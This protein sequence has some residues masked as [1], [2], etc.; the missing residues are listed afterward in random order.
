M[1]SVAMATYNGQD[2]IKEQLIS[3]LNQN[4]KLMKLLFVMIALQIIQ[5]IL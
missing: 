1:I 4:K 3:I 2:Y 5:L